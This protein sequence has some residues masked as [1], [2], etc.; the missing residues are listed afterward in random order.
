MSSPKI[1]VIITT[2]GIESITVSAAD[3]PGRVFGF[4]LCRCIDPELLELD[5]AIKK[6]TEAHD[7]KREEEF[8]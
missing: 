8:N 7:E 4:E 6:I 1:V 2:K 3:S 5:I